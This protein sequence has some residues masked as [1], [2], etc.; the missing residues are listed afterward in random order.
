MVDCVQHGAVQFDRPPA[1]LIEWRH[2]GHR[3]GYVRAIV[4]AAARHSLNLEI[5][6]QAAVLESDEWTVHLGDVPDLKVKTLPPESFEA[7]R[8]PMLLR[9]QRAAGRA[10]IIPEVDRVLHGIV[11]AFL[12]RRLPRPTTVIA[13]RPPRWSSPKAWPQ[14]IAKIVALRLLSAARGVNVLLLE[15]PLASDRTRVWRWPLGAAALRLD[16]PAD[17]PSESGELPPELS[18]LP[19]GA[20]LFAII[21]SIDARKRVPLVLD[22][23]ALR[24]E[25]DDCTLVIA[26]GHHPSVR[27]TIVDHPCASRGDVKIID[28]Y[29]SSVEHAAVID[30]STALFVLFDGGFSSGTLI[31]AARSGRWVITAAGGRPSKVAVEQGFGV[32]AE[33]TPDGVCGSVEA[34]L[35]KTALPDPVAVAG[36]EEF[37]DRILGMTG[38]FANSGPSS[39]TR[40]VE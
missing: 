3:L 38:R 18:D 16:D 23:W 21:G 10:V 34:V 39:S 32:E 8:L 15:D 36:R 26:G 33:L 11:V 2:S 40:M 29:L 37:G 17:P 24:R 28:R 31:S 6:T 5:L 35:T 27:Q 30:R 12:T 7:M 4:D 20:H 14:S 25:R 22:G 9:R 1:T 13:M 19:E